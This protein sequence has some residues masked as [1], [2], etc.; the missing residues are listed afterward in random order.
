M[1]AQLQNH[2][3]LERVRTQ[4][5]HIRYGERFIGKACFAGKAFQTITR[6]I[7]RVVIANTIFDTQ[8]ITGCVERGGVT[9]F[10]SSGDGS[11]QFFKTSSE[12]LSQGVTRIFTCVLR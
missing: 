6:G 5:L 3:G 2:S 9:S 1:V 8:E 12:R 4:S 10:H 7:K 11:V